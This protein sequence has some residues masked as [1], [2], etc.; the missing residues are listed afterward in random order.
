MGGT[1]KLGGRSP[2]TYVHV[3]PF[4]P[5]EGT[6][7]A[8]MK[9]VDG[10]VKAKRAD[11][12]REVSRAKDRAFR[13]RFAG[14]ELEAVVIARKGSGAELLT[15]NNISVVVPDCPAARR[16]LIGVRSQLFNFPVQSES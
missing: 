4:S 6:P 7:A 16:E 15:G 5:R 8:A 14:R 10:A 11:I 2:L 13:A 9:P 12:L 1:R 3:F